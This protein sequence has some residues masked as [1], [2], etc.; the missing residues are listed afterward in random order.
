MIGGNSERYSSWRYAIFGGQAA[1]LLSV[2][3][4]FWVDNAG[5]TL[6]TDFL[7]KKFKNLTTK[8]SA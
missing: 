3:K 5:T 8:A 2:G 1:A 4:K 7:G 6:I